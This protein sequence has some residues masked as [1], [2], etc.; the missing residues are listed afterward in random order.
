MQKISIFLIFFSLL[1]T[2]TSYSETNNMPKRI[3]RSILCGNVID[4]EPVIEKNQFFLNE[5]AYL[6]S[7]IINSSKED[8]IYHVWYF[9]KDD[10]LYEMARVKL[11]VSGLRW[12]TWSN[13]ILNRIGKWEVHIEDSKGN[14][15]KEINFIVKGEN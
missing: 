4:R 14:I 10:F 5:K 8:A 11:K 3:S 7:E 6:F 1:F 2:I 15:I 9:K 13:K 12:R